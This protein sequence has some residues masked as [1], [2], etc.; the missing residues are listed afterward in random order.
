MNLR[1]ESVAREAPAVLQQVPPDW[2]KLI[3]KLRW[4]GFDEEAKSLEFAASALP[5]EQRCGVSFGPFSTD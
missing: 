1:D 2:A 5:P 3:R 4:L